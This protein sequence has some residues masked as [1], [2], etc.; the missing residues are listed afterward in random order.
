ME[1]SVGSTGRIGW[2]SR[3]MGEEERIGKRRTCEMGGK[4]RER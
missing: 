2:G 4:G 3:E 1:Q